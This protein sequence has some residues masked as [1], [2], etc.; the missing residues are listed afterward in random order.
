MP[1]KV[2]KL[3]S[4]LRK[5]GFYSRPGKGSHVVFFHEADPSL[6]VTVSGRDGDD[7]DAYQVYQVK[8]AL[9]RIKEKR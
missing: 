7:A 3:K 8:R 9:K 1:L 2:K 4:E 6:R 5:E